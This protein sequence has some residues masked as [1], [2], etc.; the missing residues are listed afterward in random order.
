MAAAVLGHGAVPL[1]AAASTFREAALQ[2]G[3]IIARR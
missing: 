3:A 1:P 2:N